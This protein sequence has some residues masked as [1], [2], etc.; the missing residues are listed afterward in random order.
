MNFNK[1][2]GRYKSKGIAEGCVAALP[3]FQYMFRDYNVPAKEAVGDDSPSKSGR[4]E[5]AAERYFKSHT[6]GVW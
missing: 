1:Y 3:G 6:N 2:E 5:N 4:A